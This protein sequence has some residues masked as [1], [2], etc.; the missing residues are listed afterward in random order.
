MSESLK[1]MKDRWAILLAAT[2]NGVRV[3][4]RNL[5]YAKE[6]NQLGVQIAEREAAEVARPQINATQLEQLAWIDRMQAVRDIN[7]RRLTDSNF[8]FAQRV[9]KARARIYA[10]E[11]LP[12]TLISNTEADIV[13]I[14]A[15]TPEVVERSEP[16]I[17]ERQKAAEQSRGPGL[18]INATPPS[19][20]VAPVQPTSAR[21]VK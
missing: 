8:E 12:Q 17:A 2:Q 11:N 15:T 16:T 1:D 5:H 10:G 9:D 20:Y 21:V 7:G 19:H 4:E 13:R 3:Y 14:K 6:V 18:S